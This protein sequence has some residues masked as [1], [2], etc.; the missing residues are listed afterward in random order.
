MILKFKVDHGSFG[1][2]ITHYLDLDLNYHTIH[3]LEQHV[4]L[5]AIYLKSFGD[6]KN[7]T[8]HVRMYYTHIP[9]Q[10]HFSG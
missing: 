4:D 8:G 2:N 9:L 5:H 1:D 10:N 7:I 6:N 3:D